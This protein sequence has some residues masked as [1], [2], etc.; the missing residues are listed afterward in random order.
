M[1]T[2]ENNA[3]A[4]YVKDATM[5]VTRWYNLLALFWM[6]QFVIGCQHMIIAGAVATWFFTRNK[7]NLDSPVCGS[8]QHLVRYHLGTV[9]LGSF[10]IAVVQFVRVLFQALEVSLLTHIIL[11]EAISNKYSLNFHFDHAGSRTG[12]SKSHH[13]NIV[14]V[15]SMLFGLF[16]EVTAIF[17]A[18]CLH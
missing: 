12:S 3:S 17:D 15:L 11:E 4:K 9:A 18:K 2:V 13:S 8:I 6:T 5:K 1:L 10:L 16:R 7:S 14:H